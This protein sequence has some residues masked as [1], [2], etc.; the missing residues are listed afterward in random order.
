MIPIPIPIPV[1]LLACRPGE[2]DLP[3]GPILPPPVASVDVAKEAHAQDWEVGGHL[4]RGRGCTVGDF[5]LDG[6]PDVALANPADETYILLNE[7]TPGHLSF[8]PG[9][10]LA[11]GGLVWALSAA[12]F[13]GDGDLDLAGALGGL[14]GREYDRLL[15][16]RTV[17]TGV[18]SFDDVTDVVGIAGPWDETHTVQLKTAS[19]EHQWIDFDG[20]GDLD[21]W[22]DSTH[23]PQTWTEPP[24]EGVLGVSQLWRNDDGVFTDVAVEVGL[25]RKAS[26]RYSSW[27]DVDGD[28]DLDLHHNAMQPSLSATFRN[29]DGVFVEVENGWG[30]DGSDAR[31]PPES[32]ASTTADFNNDGW[33]D[34]LKFSRGWPSDGPHRLGHTLFLNAQGRGLVDVTEL[35]N[36]NDPFLDGLRDH[37]ANGVMGST[38]RDINGDGLPDVILGN[39]GPTGGYP[40]G[41]FVTAGL[42]EVDLGG[43]AGVLLVPRFENA[44]PLIDQPAEEDPASGLSWPPYPYRTHAL[45]VAD[46]DLDGF[47][48]LY[49][50]HGGMS[51]VGGNGA[52]EPNQLFRFTY[53]VPPHHLSVALHGDGVTVPW[54][55]VG[56]RIAVTARRGDL[57]W[58]VRDTFKTV[59]GFA[60]QHGEVRWLGLADA[61][62]IDRVEIAWPDGTVTVREDAAIDGTIE[63]WR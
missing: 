32:F 47:P 45:C 4:K 13:D 61:E 10:I 59:E 52:R 28:G 1:V 2:I 9:P 34:L 6:D 50:M 33:D 53:R 15:L 30:I 41:L 37:Q 44:Q 58:V 46:F 3:G 42:D 39:G 12:D 56:A 8:A 35:S 11:D 25:G 63:V 7:S 55:P 60:A 14:E 22:V 36:L 51:L 16:N 23:W 57:T 43:E 29:D 20:D 49:V 21:L 48:E 54:T 19:L 5:D 18:L 40:D 31:Y 27:L 17:E 24:E 26:A 62:S 38:A